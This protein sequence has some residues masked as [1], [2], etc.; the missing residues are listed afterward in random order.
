MIFVYIGMPIL[1]INVPDFFD[2]W[3]E[4][5]GR[6]P[7]NMSFSILSLAV[8]FHLGYCFWF[9]FK[10]DRYSKSIF[11][12]FFLNV[13]Y[14]PIYY[15]RV[16]IK[17]RPL[18]NK[19]NKP[20]E[21]LQEDNSI[22]DQE[23]TELTRE[24]IIGILKIWASKAEQVE[25]QESTPSINISSELF[26]YWCDYSMADSEVL[27]EAFNTKEI[28]LLSRFDSEISNVEKM[29]DGS[30]IQIEEFQKT[31]EWNK[32]NQLAEEIL[33]NFYREN[34]VGNNK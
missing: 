30:F 24:N 4:N 20:Q 7:I 17:K 33:R 3:T 9:L 28:E 34:T 18:R 27:N 22:S 21:K 11:P 10:Y 19:V 14:A 23:F 13:I 1:F 15:Y 2:A 8:V 31:S 26:E 25:L 12:L 29:Y 32:L 6:N 16:K 5:K